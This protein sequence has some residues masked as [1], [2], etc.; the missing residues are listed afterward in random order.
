MVVLRQH[1]RNERSNVQRYEW[2]APVAA[3]IQTLPPPTSAGI[4]R[5]LHALRLGSVDM[6]PEV[7][8]Y[9][10]R[11]AYQC[12]ALEVENQMFAVLMQRVRP[13]LLSYLQ[14]YRHLLQRALT[15]E[16]VLEAVFATL[17]RRLRAARGVS[18]YECAF[19]HAVRKNL[20]GY[21]ARSFA[22]RPAE[23]SLHTAA[24]DEDDLP[25]E[26]A[27]RSS[28]SPEE[29]LLIQ[30]DCTEFGPDFQA[31]LAATSERTRAAAHLM[32]HGSTQEEIA[33]RLGVSSRM[34]RYYKKELVQAFSGV[35]SIACC[36]L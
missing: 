5:L 23:V 7:L 35:R 11:T 26:W 32:M 33:A 29:Q 8:A 2:S 21:L 30:E 18:F 24:W 4:W 19:L 17:S 16:D 28:P 1:G 25:L 36:R 6:P 10:V 34:V 3:I 22:G 20:C 14:R 31:I 9:L 27:D 12:G 15:A 13:Y